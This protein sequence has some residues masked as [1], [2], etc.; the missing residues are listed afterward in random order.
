[1]LPACLVKQRLSSAAASHFQL[2]LDIIACKIK[3]L[4]DFLKLKG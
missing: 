3:A 1:M 4:K 2:S